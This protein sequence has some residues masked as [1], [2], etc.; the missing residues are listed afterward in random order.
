LGK[1]RR[2][3]HH[4]QHEHKQARYPFHHYLVLLD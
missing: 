2:Y 4:R 3:K 1:S